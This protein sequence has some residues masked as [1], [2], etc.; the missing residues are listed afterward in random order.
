MQR[1]HSQNILNRD[2][3]HALVRC[4]SKCWDWRA[5][6]RK[7]SGTVLYKA[8]MWFQRKTTPV[9]TLPKT[10]NSQNK[11]LRA[12]TV[13]NPLFS[14]NAII[15]HSST[16]EN[17]SSNRQKWENTQAWILLRIHI[18][19]VPLQCTR[20]PLLYSAWKALNTVLRELQVCGDRGLINTVQWQAR[21]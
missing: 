12:D 10:E 11:A 17:S 2:W 9:W 14:T 3:F 4:P 16:A 1:K 19:R 8:Q 21:R 15:K 18:A 13:E 5:L 6:P 7:C 20:S